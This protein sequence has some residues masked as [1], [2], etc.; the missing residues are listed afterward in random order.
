MKSNDVNK[1]LFLAL[2]FISPHKRIDSNNRILVEPLVLVSFVSSASMKKAKLFLRDEKVKVITCCE[3]VVSYL[4]QLFN[5]NF[6][7]SGLIDFSSGLMIKEGYMEPIQY[8]DAVMKRDKQNP[9]AMQK[10]ARCSKTDTPKINHFMV[11]LIQL[12]F[13]AA[14]LYYCA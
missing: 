6:K 5:N 12:G 14:V 11:K 1:N 9:D 2:E 7:N 13:V 3:N 4:F 10:M 8:F